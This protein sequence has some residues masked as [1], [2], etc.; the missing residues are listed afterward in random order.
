MAAAAAAQTLDDGNR[1]ED[2]ASASSP[3]PCSPTQRRWQCAM[4]TVTE[5]T[6]MTVHNNIV[7]GVNNDALA[8]SAVI[9]SCD[10]DDS[11]SAGVGA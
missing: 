10:D 8:S 7:D 5:Q 4:T 3:V 11:G 2:D 1:A 6:M 9:R